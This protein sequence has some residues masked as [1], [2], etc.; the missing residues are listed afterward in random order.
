MFE[1]RPERVEYGYSFKHIW[2]DSQCVLC[3]IE[4]KKSLNT[5][6]ANRSKEI[7]KQADV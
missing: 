6:V 3:W 2:L 1:L 5:F 4:N 7:K